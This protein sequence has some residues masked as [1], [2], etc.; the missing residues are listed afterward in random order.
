MLGR[1]RYSA[2]KTQHVLYFWK[3]CDFGISNMILK[4]DYLVTTW[5]NL[6][7]ILGKSFDLGSWIAIRG[8]TRI[9]DAVFL[10]SFISLQ[11]YF[12]NSF[13]I[14]CTVVLSGIETANSW[15]DSQCL[16][17]SR[18]CWIQTFQKQRHQSHVILWHM[19]L[20]AF[21]IPGC[22]DIWN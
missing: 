2:E 15:M 20:G 3:A 9:C 10:F 13:T 5:G 18:T 12:M 16:L 21:Q 17:V 11:K 6:G 1:A 7:R 4:G 14:I 8:A 19:K 22:Y